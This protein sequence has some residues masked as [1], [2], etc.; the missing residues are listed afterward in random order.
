MIPPDVD[1]G[2]TGRTDSFHYETVDP[3]T[4]QTL[5]TFEALSDGSSITWA[6]ESDSQLSATLD[7]G[8]GNYIEN[9]FYRMVRIIHEIEVQGYHHE[10]VMATMFVSNASNTVLYNTNSRKLS[11]YGPLYRYT[12]D[13]LPEDFSRDV[14][15]N[16]VDS[17]RDLVEGVGGTF[18]IGDGVDTSRTNTTAKF[19]SIGTN[20]MEVINT[21]AGW[22]GCEIVGGD[23]G[24]TIIRPYIPFDQRA[25]VY[26]FKRGEAS[27]YLDQ[28]N[29]DTNRDEPINRVV[30]YYSR[31]KKQD[32]DPWPLSD[33]VLIDV[34]NTSSY[35]YE[36]CGRRRTEVVQVSQPASQD[37]LMALAQRTLDSSS[38]AYLDMTIE[39][40]FVPGLH[41][42]DCVRFESSYSHFTGDY[43]IVQMRVSSLSP[44]CM[45]Q[46]KMRQIR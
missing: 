21:F 15:T 8:P 31:E 29:F 12:Q 18:V 36:R 1:W 41:V 35:S 39:H 30:A 20:L 40:A 32:N 28:L 37:D 6:Y 23:D 13:V 33:S 5:N 2:A 10:H 4:L 45:T 3:F 43:V 25:P 46:S 38:M 7:V 14:G 34:P 42:G 9:E 27:I 16:V 26:T 11:C 22:I 44:M 24:E 17:I 19:F